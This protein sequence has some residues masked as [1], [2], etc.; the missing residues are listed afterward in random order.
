MK[1]R[2]PAQGA[3]MGSDGEGNNALQALSNCQQG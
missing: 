1:G 2:A 3:L